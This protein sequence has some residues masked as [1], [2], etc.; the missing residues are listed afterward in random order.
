MEAATLKK[1]KTTI[2][3]GKIKKTM[4]N[5]LCRPDPVFWFVPIYLVHAVF[6]G[7]PW[8]GESGW[9]VGEPIN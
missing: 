9:A 3:K 8:I 7:V 5:V 1:N 6:L 2:S 4:K